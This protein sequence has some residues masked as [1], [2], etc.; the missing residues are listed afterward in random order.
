MLS[1]F[2][3]KTFHDHPYWTIP[4]RH[5]QRLQETARNDNTALK[6]GYYYCQEPLMWTLGNVRCEQFGNISTNKEI[7]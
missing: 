7:V 2:L 5:Q 1:N 6:T 4:L 3:P